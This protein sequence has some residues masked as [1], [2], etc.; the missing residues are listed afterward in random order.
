MSSFEEKRPK[1]LWFLAHRDKFIWTFKCQIIANQ[2]CISL[3]LETAQAYTGQEKKKPNLQRS[4]R[5]QTQVVLELLLLIVLDLFVTHSTV[6][7]E[8]FDGAVCKLN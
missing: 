1:N 2:I 3:C 6:K 4:L 8:Q 5:I 7:E